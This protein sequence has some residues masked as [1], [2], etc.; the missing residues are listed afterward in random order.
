MKILAEYENWVEIQEDNMTCKPYLLSGTN[1]PEEM[2]F[3]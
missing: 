1:I 2:L 3:E